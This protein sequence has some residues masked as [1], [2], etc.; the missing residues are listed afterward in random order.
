MREHMVTAVAAIAIVMLMAGGA[1]GQESSATI[2]TY[3]GVSYKLTDP[4]LE[5]FYTIGE[6]K[7]TT[8]GAKLPSMISIS[9]S[10]TAGGGEQAAGGGQEAGLLRGHSRANEITIANQGVE[11][12]VPL[13]QIRALR[14]TRTPA[15][16]GGLQ[17]PPYVPYYRYSV[18]VSLI[19]GEH[20]D[21]DYVNLG[22]TIVRGTA[23]NGRVEIPWEEVESIVF[24]R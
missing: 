10:A 11:T 8:E 21:A 20:V 22:G 15:S 4:S 16:V 19:G 3:Q 5:V 9:T 6:A 12:R 23:P 18:S 14:F 7:G 24:E 2:H 1:L 13:E 17:L